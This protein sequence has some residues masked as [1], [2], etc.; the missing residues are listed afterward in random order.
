MRSVLI[1]L[2]I[3][4]RPVSAQF[5]ES[6][7]PPKDEPKPVA[8]LTSDR[9]DYRFV[10]PGPPGAG[11]T[12]ERED[13]RLVDVMQGAEGERFKSADLDGRNLYARF[14][15]AYGRDVDRE[16][17]PATVHLLNRAMRDIAFTTFQAKDHYLRKRPFQDRQLQRVCGMEKAPAPEANPKDRSSYPSG[18]SSYGWGV[19]MIL[20]NLSPERAEALLKRAA[21]YGESRVVCAMHYPSDVEAG[22]VIA[23]AVVSRLLANPEFVADLEKAR[24]EQR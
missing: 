20:A 13:E 21:E 2:A 4:S 1:V 10:L 18:H 9:V 6:V 11:S 3:L 7:P 22:R 17:L 16:H 19:A 12:W 5:F 14:F 24:M 8:Y 15:E 23:A